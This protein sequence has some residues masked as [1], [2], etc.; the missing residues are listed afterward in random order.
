MLFQKHSWNWI[1]HAAF[2]KKELFA[3]KVEKAF[4]ST[5]YGSSLRKLLKENCLFLLDFLTLLHSFSLYVFFPMHFWGSYCSVLPVIQYFLA[6]VNSW[7]HEHRFIN[8][9]KKGNLYDMIFFF[10]AHIFFWKYRVSLTGCKKSL[11]LAVSRQLSLY[12]WLHLHWNCTHHKLF[13]FCCAIW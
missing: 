8:C 12:K 2:L 3:A 10:L 1:R 11:F 9:S 5:M 7:V 6:K 4:F 13:K